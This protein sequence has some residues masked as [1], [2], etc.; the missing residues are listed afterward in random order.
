VKRSKERIKGA[1]A[2]RE[3]YACD[4]DAVPEFKRGYAEQYEHNQRDDS[5]T[6]EQSKQMGVKT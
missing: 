1:L 4:P 5:R 2:C 6:V 3:G